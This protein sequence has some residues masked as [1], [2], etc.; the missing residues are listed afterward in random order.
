[1]T[2]E[3]PGCTPGQDGYFVA[4]GFAR[5][6]GCLSSDECVSGLCVL[7]HCARDVL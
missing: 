6:P 4:S 5:T 2:G 3:S 7:G 1:M